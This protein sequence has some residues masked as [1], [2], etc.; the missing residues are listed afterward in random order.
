MPEAGPPRRAFPVVQSLLSPVALAEL[1]GE[2]FG[3]RAVRCH[4]LKATIRDVYRVDSREGPS[5]LIAYRYGRRTLAEI[6][7][8]LDVLDYLALRRVPVAPAVPSLSGERIL[9][10]PAPEGTRYAVLFRFAVGTPL[11]R[12]PERD[13]A[14]RCG[15]LAAQVH[16]AADACIPQ[17]GTLSARAPIDVT[18]LVD[19]PLALVEPLLAHRPADVPLL[20]HAADHLRRRLAALPTDPPA[21]GLVHGDFI[22]PNILIDDQD[23]LTLLDF[24][25]CGLGWRAYDIASYLDD[26]DAGASSPAV[27]QSFVEGYREIQVPAA[28]EIEAVPLFLAARVLFRLGNW[29]PRVEEWGRDALTDGVIDSRLTAL[30]QHLAQ[31]A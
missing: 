22:A 13:V 19:R 3:L 28:W 4:L 21:Y 14:R 30:E 20:H 2:A 11:A 9:S 18:L 27:A 31:I 12:S 10:V 25:F 23:R 15:R 17:D 26:G 7:A 8:E 16:L 29:G 6:E 1:L 24:D 5:I